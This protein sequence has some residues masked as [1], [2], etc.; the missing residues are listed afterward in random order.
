MKSI[1]QTRFWQLPIPL[2][3]VV[4]W[5]FLSSFN[6][7][8]VLISKYIETRSTIDLGSIIFGFVYC[9][10]A[11][12]LINRSND[13]R[14]W[15]AFIAFISSLVCLFGLAISVFEDSD[16]T[17]GL[18]IRTPLT[19][20]Q[21]IIFTGAFLIINVGILFILMRPATKAFFAPQTIQAEITQ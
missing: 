16:P 17:K 15:A 19:H 10:L 13:S 5:F 8:W 18:D 12:G 1:T 11:I 6:S 14:Q 7:F 3:L 4:I 21:E 20:A 2:K 9:C